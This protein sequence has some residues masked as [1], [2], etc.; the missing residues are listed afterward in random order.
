M[1]EMERRRGRSLEPG[2]AAAAAAWRPSRT[3]EAGSGLSR[4]AAG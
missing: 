2:R 1:Q 3:A 4:Q